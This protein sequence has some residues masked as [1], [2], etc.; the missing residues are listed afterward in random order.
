MTKLKARHITE[1]ARPQGRVL[2]V[3]IILSAL[4]LIVQAV[5]H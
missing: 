3:A 1:A 5:A 2:L 4:W